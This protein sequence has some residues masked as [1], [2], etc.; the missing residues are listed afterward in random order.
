MQSRR[1]LGRDH[2]Q[3]YRGPLPDLIARGLLLKSLVNFEVF[4]RRVLQRHGARSPAMQRRLITG[5]DRKLLDP[6]LPIICAVISGGHT[7]TVS[8]SH[9]GPDALQAMNRQP[10]LLP[11]A[12]PKAQET[13]TGI[14]KRLIEIGQRAGAVRHRGRALPSYMKAIGLGPFM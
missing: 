8:F 12:A 7:D 5:A 2:P 11:Q 4:T 10:C 9:D 1:F 14:R 13:D 6:T 3:T